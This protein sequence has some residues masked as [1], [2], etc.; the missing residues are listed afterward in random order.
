[1]LIRLLALFTTA[2]PLV[3]ADVKFL[4]PAAGASLSSGSLAVTWEESGTPPL[5]TSLGGWTLSL[6]VGGNND[7][8]SVGTFVSLSKKTTSLIF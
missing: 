5:I 3:S 1:M 8:V 4:T 7:G 2:I 6:M